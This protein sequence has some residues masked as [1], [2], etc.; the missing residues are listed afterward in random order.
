MIDEIGS[1][2]YERWGDLGSVI[3]VFL[4]IIFAVI[5]SAVFMW[6]MVQLE[7]FAK[8]LW[9][10]KV[11]VGDRSVRVFSVPLVALVAISIGATYIVH[12]T[13]HDDIWGSKAI[14]FAVVITLVWSLITCRLQGL[15][16]GPVRILLGFLVFMAIATVV[17]MIV[18]F[19]A[20]ILGLIG[21][22]SSSP[23]SITIW[24][25]GRY[26]NLKRVSNS[27]YVDI[28]TNEQYTYDGSSVEDSSGER[29]DIS[30]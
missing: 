13:T 19:V 5:V 8:F 14:I 4:G 6:L 28:S 3:L 21:G 16:V 11:I 15:W 1:Y 12:E 20:T 9:Y 30:N 27:E 25:N 18:V 26:V 7:K 2:F 17:F 10:T 22:S 24:R 23:E 29:Y